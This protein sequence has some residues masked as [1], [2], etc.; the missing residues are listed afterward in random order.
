MQSLTLNNTRSHYHWIP[1]AHHFHSHLLSHLQNHHCHSVPSNLLSRHQSHRRYLPYADLSSSESSSL[2]AKF[3]TSLP[4]RHEA[5]NSS[6]RLMP[7]MWMIVASLSVVG[8]SRPRYLDSKQ[9]PPPFAIESVRPFSSSSR[10][11]SARETTILA[12]GYYAKEIAI[13]PPPPPLLTKEAPPTSC[14]RADRQYHPLLSCIATI[15]IVIVFDNDTRRRLAAA[16]FARAHTSLLDENIPPPEEVRMLNSLLRDTV[17]D[18]SGAWCAGRSRGGGGTRH[19]R[20]R[21]REGVTWTTANAATAMA[22]RHVEE[23]DGET[24]TFRQSRRQRR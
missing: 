14:D 24:A 13:A 1:T 7:S 23:I 20:R 19:Q 17:S 3:L 22:E 16:V 6:P 10:Y 21:G 5:N 11:A 2:P 15:I 4:R 8:C 18:G 9:P 12:V